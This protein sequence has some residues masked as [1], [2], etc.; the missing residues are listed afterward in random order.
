M[1]LTKRK[2]GAD[3]RDKVKHKGR[4]DQLFLEKMMKVAWPSKSNNGCKASTARTL[5]GDEFMKV[6]RLGSCENFV[7]K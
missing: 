1:R 3:S 7:G 5:N 6:Q 4:S 2:K